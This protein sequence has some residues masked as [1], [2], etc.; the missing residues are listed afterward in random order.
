MKYYVYILFDGE[1]PFYVGKGT[2]NRM[3]EHYRK[4]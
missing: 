4:E 3:Y 2:G 1:L